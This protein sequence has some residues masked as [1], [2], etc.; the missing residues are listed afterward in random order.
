MDASGG[1][2][3]GGISFNWDNVHEAVGN[4]GRIARET[5]EHLGYLGQG[6]QSANSG[7]SRPAHQPH[8]QIGTGNGKGPNASTSPVSTP[9][10]AAYP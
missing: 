2:A 1:D 3:T 7:L 10:A 5:G 8:S 4:L 9:Q 6:A